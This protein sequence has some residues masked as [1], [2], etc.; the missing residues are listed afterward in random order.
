M[1]DEFGNEISTDDILAGFQSDL[2]TVFWPT[3]TDEADI[4]DDDRAEIIQ[5]ME[6]AEDAIKKARNILGVSSEND[7]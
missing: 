3:V 5:L 7:T 1:R 4:S 6:G 2:E